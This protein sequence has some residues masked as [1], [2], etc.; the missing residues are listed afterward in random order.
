[1]RYSVTVVKLTKLERR[2]VSYCLGEIKDRDPEN[3]V[4]PT[5]IS[6]AREQ[7]RRAELLLENDIQALSKKYGFDGIVSTCGQYYVERY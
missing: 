7:V 1:M 4:R 3:F 5:I 6:K 2:H